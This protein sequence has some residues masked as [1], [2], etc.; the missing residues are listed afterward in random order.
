MRTIT[1][2]ILL[3][4]SNGLFAQLEIPKYEA[5]DIIIRHLRYTY[6]YNSKYKQANWVVYLLTKYEAVKRF[7]CM[8]FLHLIL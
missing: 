4:I 1:F 3:F 2:L 6:S 7:Q 5:D 8:S